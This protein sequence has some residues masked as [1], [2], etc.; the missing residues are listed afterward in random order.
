MLLGVRFAVG[1]KGHVCKCHTLK[2]LQ[3]D[4]ALVLQLQAVLQLFTCE[5]CVW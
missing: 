4:H 5:C 3:V 1:T 2:Q